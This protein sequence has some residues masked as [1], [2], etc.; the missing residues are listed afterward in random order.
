VGPTSRWPN[1]RARAREPRR[2]WHTGPA[3][4][5]GMLWMAGAMV[6]GPK[7]GDLAQV[8][9]S[10]FIFFFFYMFFFLF[11]FSNSILNIQTKF[12][13]YFEFQIPKIKHNPEGNLD[14]I[15][16]IIYLFLISIYSCL[17]IHFLFLIPN[18]NLYFYFSFADF[19]NVSIETPR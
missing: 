5:R 1:E 9:F 16:W 12:K 6:S 13:F 15:V 8:R 3:C 18:S 17:P 19:S 11:L 10:L 2:G 14:F 7:Q 4:R